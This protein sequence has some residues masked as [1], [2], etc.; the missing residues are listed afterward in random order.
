[1]TYDNMMVDIE[2]G[3]IIEMVLLID[4]GCIERIAAKKLTNNLNYLLYSPSSFIV[5]FPTFT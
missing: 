3:T 5:K 4:D 1:M 2:L